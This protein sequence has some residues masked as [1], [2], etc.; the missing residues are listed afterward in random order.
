[1]TGYVACCCEPGFEIRIRSTL[2]KIWTSSSIRFGEVDRDDHTIGNQT[3]DVKGRFTESGR[4]VW[5]MGSSVSQ[6]FFSFGTIAT[7]IDGFVDLNQIGPSGLRRIPAS[8][9]I[10]FPGLSFWTVGIGDAGDCLGVEDGT[11][12]A[13]ASLYGTNAP[14]SAGW[15]RTS[16]DLNGDPI[17]SDVVRR[18][19]IQGLSGGTVQVPMIDD[20]SR[21]YR[22]LNNF[23]SSDMDFVEDLG[24]FDPTP[25]AYTNLPSNPTDVSVWPEFDLTVDKISYSREQVETRDPELLCALRRCTE[26]HVR[27]EFRESANVTFFGDY[28]TTRDSEIIE[29]AIV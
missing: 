13:R 11:I 27:Y 14:E 22:V 1:M 7:T 4:E 12:Y 23:P 19:P 3:L 16:Y 10:F 2:S 28:L 15:Q 18:T 9:P 26:V 25:G 29:Y 24:V 5:D 17:A 20:V 21:A 6:D 8:L